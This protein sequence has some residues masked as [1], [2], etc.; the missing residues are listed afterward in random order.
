M[1]QLSS[2]AVRTDPAYQNRGGKTALR[3]AAF[4]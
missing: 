4:R 1:G 3:L 2:T